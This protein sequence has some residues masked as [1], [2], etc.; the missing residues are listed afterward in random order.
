[1]TKFLIPVTA[2]A[3]GLACLSPAAMAKDTTTKRQTTA[4]LN[5]AELA[6]IN[7][8]PA[9]AYAE[10]APAPREADPTVVY[11][12]GPPHD[13]NETTHGMGPSPQLTGQ[14]STDTPYVEV[15]PAPTGN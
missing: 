2:L 1:M 8:E 9:P 4:D 10:A 7:A 3:I 6:R 5:R 13:A 11:V 14:P 12:A 15:T